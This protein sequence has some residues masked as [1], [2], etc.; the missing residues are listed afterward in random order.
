[1]QLFASL[2]TNQF[3]YPQYPRGIIKLKKEFAE[4]KEYIMKLI[5]L[6]FLAVFHFILI[7]F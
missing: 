1:V 3:C 5:A 6:G 7:Y 2:G 4:V